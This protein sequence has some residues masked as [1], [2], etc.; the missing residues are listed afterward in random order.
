MPKLP[1]PVAIGFTNV[2]QDVPVA[3]DRS[4]S[5]GAPTVQENFRRWQ[6]LDL[7]KPSCNSR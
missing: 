5:L 3:T 7:G 2:I 4:Q 1:L 6:V